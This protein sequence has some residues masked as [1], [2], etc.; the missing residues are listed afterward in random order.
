M[1]RG[2]QLNVAEHPKAP[3]GPEGPRQAERPKD[4]P[5]GLFKEGHACKHA[6]ADCKPAPGLWP[7]RGGPENRAVMATD[8]GGW[9]KALHP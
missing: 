4:L 9:N 1:Q 2:E 7:P 8:T 3:A 6:V 5:T